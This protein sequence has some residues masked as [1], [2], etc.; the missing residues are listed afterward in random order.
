M[1]YKVMIPDDEE[2]REMMKDESVQKALDFD[3]RLRAALDKK[4]EE[5]MKDVPCADKHPHLENVLFNMWAQEIE[6]LVNIDKDYAIETLYE[7]MLIIKQKIKEFS[8]DDVSQ[9]GGE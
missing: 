8:Q 7:D 3:I 5:L 1:G 6:C 2:S 9:E 4:V